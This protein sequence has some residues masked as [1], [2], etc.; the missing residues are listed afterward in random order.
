MKYKF[1]IKNLNCANCAREV[2]KSLNEDKKIN[3]A[4]VNFNTSTITVETDVDDAF[5]YVKEIVAMIE[6]DA[7]LSEEK[8]ESDNN[9][10]VY[11]LLI[12]AVIGIL[13]IVIKISPVN[14][15]LIVI[16]YIILIYKTLLTALKQLKNRK[17]NENF[18]VSISAIGAYLL[19][20]HH[21][22]LMVIFL[23]EL[24]KMLEAKA[25]ARSR[26]SVSELMN[27]KEELS[28]LK[29]NNKIKKV[30]TTEVS[31]GDIIVVK[32]G[33]RVPLDGIVIKGNSLVD[34]S[35]LTGESIPVSVKQG[36]VLLSGS[37]NKGDIL[38]IKVTSLYKDSTVSKILELVENATER[39]AKAETIVSK[40]SSKYTL[41]VIIIA[42]LVSFVLPLVSSLSLSKCIYKGLTILVISCPCA[43]AISVPL[44]YFSGIGR[45]SKEG[46]LVKGS[47]Y[48]DSIKDISDIAFDK[49]GTITT[50]EFCISKINIYDKKY[51]EDKIM[52][53]FT[54][55]EAL[56]NHPIAKSILKKHEGEVDFSCVKNFKEVSGS[57]ISFTYRKDSV[58]I[59]SAKFCKS[60][61]VNNN[62]YLS[63]NDKVVASLVIEDDIKNCTIDTISKLKELGINVYMF[64]GD[65]KDKAISIASK[66]G[67]DNVNYEMLPED[68]YNS[69]EHIIKNK[70]GVVAFVG[71]GINDAPVVKLA[72]LGI[73]MGL[74]GSDS[75]IEA[76]DIVIM[77]DDIS[78]ILN[79]IKISKKTSR[80]IKE[81]L[82]FAFGIK[83]T[84]LILA[85]LGLTSMFV[86]VF[87]DVG[88]TILC[89]LNTLRILKNN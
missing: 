66:V 7:I 64:T 40:Y 9:K 30:P 22:G 69:L 65:S 74:N 53:I 6:P 73:S 67:I 85:I 55:G 76:S 33:E 26:N 61:D 84:V 4:V 19:G 47:N 52:E 42:L 58:K 20:K 37:I 31:I 78:K 27:I 50:G 80:I 17:I 56:S 38:E 63:I 75:A 82:I 14:M 29:V 86:A 88:V 10:D 13:G 5:S 72:D 1:N 34:T 12:G 62:I 24:G 87:A 43:I 15:I 70:R 3:K 35:F 89:I 18:L 16:A 77:N 54:S 25:V 57:G 71:D 32:E 21:E 60:K 44:S 11:R 36:S 23:Y 79:A 48:L 45:A 68:K 41:A 83:I 2:E 49:T 28:N 51:N 46:I 59:G 39:K 8:I 81:N